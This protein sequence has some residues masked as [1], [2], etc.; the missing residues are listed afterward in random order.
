MSLVRAATPS[1]VIAVKKYN[2][3]P[4]SREQVGQFVDGAAK[5]SW[6][7]AQ[8]GAMLMAIWLN[9]MNAQETFDLA[10]LMTESGII[11]D[12]S[13]VEGI[14]VDKHSCG[15]VGDYTS[16][17]IAALVSSYGLIV[18][19]MSGRG[20]GHTGGTLDTLE[21][22]P[23][24][25]VDLTIEQINQQLNS[26]GLGIFGPTGK[27][28]PADKKLYGM[29]DVTHTVDSIPLIAASIMSKKLA[30]GLAAGQDGLVL[31]VTCGSG[32]FMPD[33]EN[34]KKLAETMA[35]IA[36]NAGLNVSY[37]ISSMDQP[38]GNYIGNA[39]AV[40]QVLRVLNGKTEGFENYVDMVIELS[41]HM[42]VHGG[43][44]KASELAAAKVDLRKRLG[45]DKV[46][47]K[48]MEMVIAQ[49]GDERLMDDPDGILPSAKH[50][51]ELVVP[52]SGFIHKMEPTPIGMAVVELRGG[53]KQ[54]GDKLDYGTGVVL[55]E[56]RIGD[57]VEA[58]ETW[59]T[60][61][62]NDEAHIGPARERLES[63][64]VVGDEQ[65]D[66]PQLILES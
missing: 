43:K 57:E 54:D 1:E 6:S 32:A 34:A 53:R 30:E 55:T 62:A 46:S 60:I 24:Y 26:I 28:A 35:T 52:Q 21:A 37:V 13:G 18:P 20:L 51:D 4:L 65:V 23:G 63:A 39:L 42:L 7:D 8:L 9:G 5:D 47:T 36:R 44:Y 64:L 22:I 48:F 66:A 50:F 41:A 15:G 3:G 12:L 10:E 14:K 58:G 16:L 33:F 2:N 11:L 17:V 56:K 27:V 29:R 49:G 59:A 45:T 38:L 25:S 40:K 61:H 19:M 31:N